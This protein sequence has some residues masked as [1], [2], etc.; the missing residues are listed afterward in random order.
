MS[1]RPPAID[2]D[3]LR[4]A[5]QASLAHAY[6]PYSGFHVG[7][8][9][10]S[11]DGR[12]FVGVNVENASYGLTVCAE[13]NAVAAAVVAGARQVVALVVACSGDTP[14]PPCGACRQVLSEFSRA[15]T[16][17]AASGVAPG[18]PIRC[19]GTAG[20]ALETRS[21]EL[22]PYAFGPGHFVR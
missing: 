15:V 5:A 10:L 11:E 8:A 4:A 18:F 12:V 14:A 19:Y 22:L 2:W 13:R 16:G 6:A 21:D 3:A 1:A 7:A 9:L 20:A 17:D